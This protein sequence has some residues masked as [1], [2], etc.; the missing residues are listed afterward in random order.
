M[1]Y[2]RLLLLRAIYSEFVIVYKI[3]RNSSV[4]ESV[5]RLRSRGFEEEYEFKKAK[6][7]SNTLNIVVCVWKNGKL[8]CDTFLPER[9]QQA[10]VNMI[11]AMLLIN[12][13]TK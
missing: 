10:E 6:N 2:N 7:K 8:F 5:K 4:D 9:I 1:K 13:Y 11:N 3:A 12:D